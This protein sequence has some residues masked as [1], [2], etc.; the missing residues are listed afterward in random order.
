MNSVSCSTNLDLTPSPRPAFSIMSRCQLQIAEQQLTWSSF[1]LRWVRTRRAGGQMRFWFAFFLFRLKVWKKRDNPK[2][3]AHVFFSKLDLGGI[4]EYDMLM[5]FGYLE[6]D[7]NINF[8]KDL[9]FES[10]LWK[11]GVHHCWMKSMS[12]SCSSWESPSFV[13][14]FHFSWKLVQDLLSLTV[15]MGVLMC[16]WDGLGPRF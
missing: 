10:C 16:L 9:R 1:T 8:K 5:H 6:T 2:I 13:T 3:V 15:W 12:C 14:G 11:S 7:M 4:L